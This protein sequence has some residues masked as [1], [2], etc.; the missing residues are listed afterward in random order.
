[1]LPMTLYGKYTLMFHSSV[2]VDLDKTETVGEF[3]SSQRKV[4]EDGKSQGK[5]GQ[6]S[7]VKFVLVCSM[8]P[9]FV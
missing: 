2:A 8:L 5:W 6:K 7:W 1:M 3:E 4:G 9:Y